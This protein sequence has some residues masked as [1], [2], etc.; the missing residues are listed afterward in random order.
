MMRCANWWPISWKPCTPPRVLV[1]PRPRSNVHRRVIV[2]D[3]SEE[4]NQPLVLIN[5]QILLAEGRAPAEEGCL[6]VPDI[7]DKVQ[8]AT[9]I[10]RAGAGD[11]WATL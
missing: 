1:W 10:P 7:Y 5:P 4:R 9:L 8:R 11:R 2:I 3:V 6:S